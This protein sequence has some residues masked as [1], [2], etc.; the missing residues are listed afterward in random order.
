MLFIIIIN[1]VPVLNGGE[2]E[3]ILLKD[4]VYNF[5][6]DAGP[7]HA[8]DNMDNVNQNCNTKSNT[9]SIVQVPVLNGGEDETIL[10]KDLVYNFVYDSGPIHAIDNM[11][12]TNKNCHA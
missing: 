3:T 6:Y 5:I 2:D 7:I 9:F 8:I 1:Q 10:L 11:E 12:Q 4:L